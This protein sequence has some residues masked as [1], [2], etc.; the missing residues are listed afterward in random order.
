[1]D[2]GRAVSSLPAGCSF[3]APRRQGT[4]PS[5]RLRRDESRTEPARGL[6]GALLRGDAAPEQPLPALLPAQ[7]GAQLRSAPSPP[8]PVP[9]GERSRKERCGGG[10]TSRRVSGPRLGFLLGG[11]RHGGGGG[12]RSARTGAPLP[13]T[14]RSPLPAEAAPPVNVAAPGLRRAAPRHRGGG[15]GPGPAQPGPPGTE[16]EAR[17][18][19]LPHPPR[20]WRLRGVRGARV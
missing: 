6:R 12:S 19:P 11:R 15:T 2:V 5:L 7:P 9:G 17:P 18:G 16:G 20:G 10:S 13:R 3:P 4:A 1:M 8:R 14:G